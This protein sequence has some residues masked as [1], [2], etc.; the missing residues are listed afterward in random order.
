MMSAAAV[1][2]AAA[3]TTAA[4]AAVVA[5]TVS[6]MVMIPVPAMIGSLVFKPISIVEAG[7]D[8]YIL[9]VFVISVIDGC[10]YLDFD[11]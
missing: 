4:A 8:P 9:S 1:V 2:S 5:M 6:V 10:A 11:A 7:A 3:V